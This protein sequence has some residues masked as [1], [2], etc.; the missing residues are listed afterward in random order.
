MHPADHTYF[1]K[2]LSEH[3]LWYSQMSKKPGIVN[4]I[5]KGV[6]HKINKIIPEKIHQVI[7]GA[8]KEITKGVLFG[9]GFTTFK[10]KSFT[11]FVEQEQYVLGRITFYSS[12]SAAEGAITGY[13]GF[14]SSL[15]DFPLWL[16]LK[17]KMLFEIANAY[18]LDINDYKERLYLLHIFQ[19]T[20]SSQKYR[21]EVFNTMVHWELKKE[22]LPS[23]HKEFDWR[24]FQLEYRDF[25]DL[26]KLIQLIPGIGA[27]AGA[28]I[29]HTYTKKL[30]KNAMNAYRMRMAEFAEKKRLG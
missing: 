26:A 11:S 4:R 3:R 13:G 29:N 24:T 17:M 6:Q 23:S 9:A 21:N 20:F 30:G 5:T 15:A 1:L 22:N 2:T 12:S 16:T 19:L 10:K 7:T 14:I 8:V 27:I 28:Y 18:G 25:I